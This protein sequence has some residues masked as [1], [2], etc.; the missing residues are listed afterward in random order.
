MYNDEISIVRKYG[1]IRQSNEVRK[2]VK[3]DVSCLF[4]VR[5]EGR[6]DRVNVI[7]YEL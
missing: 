1:V 7:V 2:F 4:N 6:D 5:I 3:E